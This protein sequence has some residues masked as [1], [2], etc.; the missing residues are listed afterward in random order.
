MH[1]KGETMASSDSVVAQLE[2]MRDLFT[3]ES[4]K[5]VIQK[6]I[7]KLKGLDVVLDVVRKQK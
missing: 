3:S 5:K 2:Q 6:Q 7:D 4:E 1:S